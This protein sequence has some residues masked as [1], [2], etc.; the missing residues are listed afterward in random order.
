MHVKKRAE[1]KAF[2][3]RSYAVAQCET[4]ICLY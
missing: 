3:E 4:Q 1:V 2:A